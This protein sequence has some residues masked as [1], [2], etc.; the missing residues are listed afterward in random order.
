MN[1]C[2]NC[3][4]DTTNPKFCCSSCSVTSQNKTKHWRKQH[5]ILKG[6]PKCLNCDNLCTKVGM[7][8]CSHFCQHE[9]DYK[10]CRDNGTLG[11][12]G[13]KR[14]LAETQGYK[15]SEC[16]LTDWNG[17]QIVLELEHKDGNSEN[18]AYTNLCLI[19]PNCHSQTS[20]YK[21][22]NKGNGRHY[23]RVRY[24]NGKSY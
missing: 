11:K 6:L 12:K 19:C 24:A 14:Y 1:K 23:R 4:I 7:K 16:G 17:K 10:E 5:G 9:Y 21:G 13:L 3:G 8:Y 22:R 20:T 2:Q 15:C 18:N